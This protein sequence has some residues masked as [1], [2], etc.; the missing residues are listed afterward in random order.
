MTMYVIYADLTDD[1]VTISTNAW[2][3]CV[4]FAQ[5]HDA[6]VIRVTDQVG[7]LIYSWDAD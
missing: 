2:K 7:Q 3:A 4:K 6:I 5:R 1:E